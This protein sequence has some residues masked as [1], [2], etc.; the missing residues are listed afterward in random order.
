M[1]SAILT[2][3]GARKLLAGEQ[4]IGQ[5]IRIGP[6]AYEVVGIVEAAEAGAG[7]STPDQQVDAYIP[8][9]VAKERYGDIT[10]K[11]AAG[12]ME[13]EQVELHQILVEVDS[14]EHVESTAA[15]AGNDAA[16]VPQEGGL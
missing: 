7:I 10:M 11:Q 3:H 2:E 1:P 15:G 13:R 5:M 16:A 4:T 8:L 12:S 6:D 14:R 9:N